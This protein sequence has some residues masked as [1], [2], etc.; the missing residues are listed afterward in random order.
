[1]SETQKRV[2]A[3]NKHCRN[4]D[5]NDCRYSQLQQT[6]AMCFGKFCWELDTGV[7]KM[8][9]SFKREAK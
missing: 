5:C 1:M 4:V 6:P 9:Q 3:F 8:H 7:I 2:D